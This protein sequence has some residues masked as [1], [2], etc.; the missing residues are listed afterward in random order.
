MSADPLSPATPLIVTAAIPVST[1]TSPSLGDNRV[2]EPLAPVT[3]HLGHDDH[4]CALGMVLRRALRVPGRVYMIL[5]TGDVTASASLYA[6]SATD[7]P[8]I[9]LS[10][11]MI[12]DHMPG[13]YEVRV[14]VVVLVRAGANRLWR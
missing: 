9:V 5:Q 12:I 3:L 8:H 4:S 11:T 7:L 6:G 14:C 1:T 10:S 2:P 13:M